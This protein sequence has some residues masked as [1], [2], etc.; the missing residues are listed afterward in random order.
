MN[1][2]NWFGPIKKKGRPVWLGLGALILGGLMLTLH[3]YSDRI[4][5]NPGYVSGINY[6]NYYIPSFWIRFDGQKKPFVGPNVFPKEVGELRA[7]SGGKCCV[8]IPADYDPERKVTVDWVSDKVV[9]GKTVPNRFRAAVMVPDYGDEVYGVVVHFLTEDRIR[10]QIVTE[11]GVMPRIPDDDV[12]VRQGV[13]D[14]E[15]NKKAE[16]DQ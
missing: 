8:R 7:E 11:R 6:T 9:D 3:S 4:G 2:R 5:S 15:P 1:A 10:V 16:S 14:S 13:L 12:F